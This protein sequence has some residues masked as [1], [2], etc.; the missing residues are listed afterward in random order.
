MPT[1]TLPET[2]VIR[3]TPV[4]LLIAV[5]GMMTICIAAAI[6]LAKWPFSRDKITRDLEDATQG[7]VS[8]Q[9][10]HSTFFPPG[11][12]AENVS[13][14][15]S[16]VL[17]TPSPVSIERLVFRTSYSSLLKKHV[18]VVEAR[19]VSAVIGVAGTT[20][21][22]L[23]EATSSSG[24]I[25]DKFE[26]IGGS[27]AVERRQGTPPLL[28][29][30]RKAVF[31]TPG[32]HAAVPFEI[33]V[34]NPEPPGDLS[35]KGSFGP[36]NH[37]H[38]LL[39]P[40][41][42][43]YTFSRAD[44]A[45][46]GGIAGTLNS[47]GT[48]TGPIAQLQIAGAIT[49]SNFETKKAEHELPLSVKFGATVETRKDTVQFNHVTAQLEDSVI[50]SDGTIVSAN[51]STRTAADLAVP[52]GRIQDF[53]FLLLRQPRPPMTG[54]FTFRGKAALPSGNGSF[55]Q[56]VQ[57]TGDFGID[58]GKFTNPKTQH[59]I[60]TLSET[61]E[62]EPND[63]PES[64]VSDLRGHVELK[65]GTFTL[66]RLSFHAPGGVAKLQGTYNLLTQSIDLHGKILTEAALSHE[67][68]GFKSFLLKIIGP[69][70][71]KNHRGGAV[72][73]VSI[74]GIYPHA[75]Y[76]TDPM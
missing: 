18:A 19:N 10:F 67:T 11:C 37:Q 33:T 54:A 9:K 62:G 60:E 55:E 76:K 45:N 53:L 8:V 35:V 42:G 2:R 36:W 13:I 48:F 50:D 1:T 6:L 12:V 56:R 31:S 28:F 4:W 71:K 64:V 65:N 20:G 43:S 51:G 7:S 26:I 63:T 52:H 15:H 30:I 68:T 27:I 25:I 66:T 38:A 49:V 14:S 72:I 59:N 29:Q 24:A 73:P 21:S 57:L 34:H 61:A 47:T 22:A 5:A 40:I 32:Q 16:R 3:R 75:I 23:P 39:T 70:L 41:A 44:L 17:N 69:F 74:T 46:L 58:A